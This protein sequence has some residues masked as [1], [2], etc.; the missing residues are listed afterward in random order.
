MMIS[1]H[2]FV[3]QVSP[4]V[5]TAAFLSWSGLSSGSSPSRSSLQLTMA[6]G[7][8]GRRWRSVSMNGS[9]TLRINSDLF[10]SC[11]SVLKEH[12]NSMRYLKRCMDWF[13]LTLFV[14]LTLHL[15]LEEA[16]VIFRPELEKPL[17][18]VLY[19]PDMIHVLN[20][21]LDQGHPD[22]F[23]I[24]FIWYA[25]GAALKLCNFF[26]F[27]CTWSKFYAEEINILK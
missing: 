1:T 5:N 12:P 14:W 19:E 27:F 24:S 25:A 20:L 21:Q 7:P 2:L 4:I 6:A 26:F 8:T 9:W 11:L 16:V 22:S 15:N 23:T 13:I 3:W 17:E 10:S 18:A